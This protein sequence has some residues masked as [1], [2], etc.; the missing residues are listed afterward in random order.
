[1]P[2]R[3][4]LLQRLKQ[5]VLAML[6]LAAGPLQAAVVPYV[7]Y[8]YPA[9]GQAGTELDITIGGQHLKAFA[10]LH[11]SGLEISAENIGY[12]R[13]YERQEMGRVRRQIEMLEVQKSEAQEE[14]VKRQI[15]RALE[16][17]EEEQHMIREQQRNDRRHPVQSRRRQFNPQIAERIAVRL[18]LPPDAAPGAYELRVST[19]DGLSNPMVFMVGAQPEVMETEPND[20]GTEAQRLAPLP[21]VINGRIMPGDED[22]FR[23]EAKAGQTLLLQAEARTLIPYLADAVPG[24]FQ[25]VLTL[26]DGQGRE[27]ACNDDFYFH[28]D[29]ALIFKVPADGVYSVNIHD[30]IHRGREDFVYRLTIKEVPAVTRKET[31][32]REMADREMELPPAIRD[33][34]LPDMEEAEPNN[35]PEQAQPVKG[36]H[37]VRGVIHEPGDADWFRFEGRQGEVRTIE[38]YARRLGSPLDGRLMLFD[39]QHKLL[40]VND[41]TQ[42]DRY[43]LLTHHADPKIEITLP[44]S[45]TF[46]VRLDETQRKGGP[47][48]TY[49]M[50]LAG[51]QPD[52]ALRVTPSGLNIPQQGAAAV[53]VHVYRS[54]RFAGPVELSLADAPEGITLPP[55]VIPEGADSAQVLIRASDRAVRQVVPLVMEGRADVGGVMRTRRAVPAEDRMQAF[56]WRHLVPARELLA[57]ITAP[58]PVTLTV[59]RERGQALKAAPGT[60]LVLPVRITRREGARGPVKLSL[61]DPPE[62]LTLGRT[63]VVGMHDRIVLKISPNAEPGDRTISVLH[64]TLRIRRSEDDPDFNPFLRPMNFKDYSFAIDAVSIEVMDPMETE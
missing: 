25:A 61:I 58:E 7:G 12:T 26:Y 45:G 36:P 52:F 35:H 62:W 9:G 17:M 53:T 16:R 2:M 59:A 49:L 55:T 64:G 48:Y 33:A 24:W 40:A 13:M 57:Q 39:P 46:H 15:D 22:T 27:I 54:G 37:L 19:P 42:D 29:P 14:S 60:E 28:P 47:E 1:M 10:A 8:V 4:P 63:Q 38:V 32:L 21:Q 51:P 23:F 44:E 6:L 50:L 30:A 11:L 5:P 56:L 43:G 41:D 3:R 20:R 18:K 34:G 31:L